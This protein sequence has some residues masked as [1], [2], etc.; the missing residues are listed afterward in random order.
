MTCRDTRRP[1][2][3][4]SIHGAGVCCI[5]WHP[6][7]EFLVAT[8]S[9]DERVR[10]WD[11]RT[12]RRPLVETNCGGGVWR[13]RWGPPG[14]DGRVSSLAAACMHGGC[15][16]LQLT[17][18]VSEVAGAGY[19]LPVTHTFAEHKS[20][21]Y[22]IDWLSPASEP[23]SHTAERGMTGTSVVPEGEYN[24]VSCSFYDKAIFTWSAPKSFPVI[25][26]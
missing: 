11:E 8:G 4:N 25:R 13:L 21:A 15:R 6:E 26:Q 12:M 19:L 5:S 20:L 18:P 9:Y 14:E 24:L 2:F 7:L 16:V 22:G 10:L 17:E 3:T 1:T 23:P